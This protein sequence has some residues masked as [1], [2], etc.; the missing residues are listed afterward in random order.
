MLEMTLMSDDVNIKQAAIDILTILV[1]FSPSVIREYILQQSTD[2]GKIYASKK[3]LF[4][5]SLFIILIFCP[6][7]T[8]IPHSKLQVIVINVISK[9]RDTIRF[10]GVSFTQFFK[11]CRK[12][13]HFSFLYVLLFLLKEI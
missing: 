4:A 1:E 2:T 13:R 12:I 8:K 5:I 3:I 11:Y 7:K 9:G 6:K 10:E